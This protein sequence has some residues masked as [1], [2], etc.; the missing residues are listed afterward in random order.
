MNAWLYFGQE[1]LQ[2]SGGQVGISKSFEQ[3]FIC[4]LD[5]N[6]VA[7]SCAQVDMQHL[8]LLWGYFPVY[9]AAAKNLWDTGKDAEHH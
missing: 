9:M 4:G 1:F 8:L 5:N 2:I 3:L 6:D 7:L